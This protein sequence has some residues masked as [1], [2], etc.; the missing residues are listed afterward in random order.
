MIQTAIK[1]F[2]VDK[3]ITNIFNS[4]DNLFIEKKASM[5][6]EGDFVTRLVIR[7]KISLRIVE[8]VNIYGATFVCVDGGAI[9]LRN[10]SRGTV[11]STIDR[12]SDVTESVNYSNHMWEQEVR[13]YE[14][15]SHK[16]PITSE[17]ITH[18]SLEFTREPWFY[19]P[20]KELRIPVAYVIGVNI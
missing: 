8:V 3:I 6:N 20:K 10:I 2:I 7:R 19:D 16:L 12:M 9:I 15:N 4:F 5:L 17:T 13:N 14:E 18:N 1:Y 11:K